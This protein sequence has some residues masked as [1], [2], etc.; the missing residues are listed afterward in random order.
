MKIL[1]YTLDLDNMIDNYSFV[2]NVVYTGNHDNNTIV[3]W[4]NNLTVLN[5]SKLKTFL[6]NNGIDINIE[7]NKA[8]IKYLLNTSSKNDIVIIPVQDILGLDD[9]NRINLPGVINNKN[10]SWKM[11]N[12]DDFRKCISIF[13]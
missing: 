1:Q 4:Y 11:K 3:G 5:K 7:I 13:N 9:N 2:N 6:M 12:F 8:I 10:W